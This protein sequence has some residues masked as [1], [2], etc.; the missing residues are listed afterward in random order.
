MQNRKAK[1]Q[2][3]TFVARP[4]KTNNTRK[5]LVRVWCGVFALV[6]KG[7]NETAGF[8]SKQKKS[9]RLHAELARKQK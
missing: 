2:Q 6:K 5:R 3:N 4:N 8:S 7:K 9:W 1:N